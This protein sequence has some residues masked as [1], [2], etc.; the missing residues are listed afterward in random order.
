MRILQQ[1]QRVFTLVLKCFAIKFAK[2]VNLPLYAK[3]ASL[4]RTFS[5]HLFIRKAYEK[6]KTSNAKVLLYYG[7]TRFVAVVVCRY[8]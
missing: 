7:Y 2:Q 1:P 8:G 6:E 5:N 3:M 4:L